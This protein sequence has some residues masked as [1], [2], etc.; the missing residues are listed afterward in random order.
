MVTNFTITGFCGSNEVMLVV[1]SAGDCSAA[2]SLGWQIGLACLGLAIM[3][4]VVGVIR[5]WSSSGDTR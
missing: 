4:R 5:G 2:M 3:L 1:Q